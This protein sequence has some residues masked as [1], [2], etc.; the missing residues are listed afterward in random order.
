MWCI[1]GGE[2]WLYTTAKI[3]AILDDATLKK[4]PNHA[5]SK[6]R[7][8]VGAKIKVNFGKVE[9]QALWFTG[10]VTSYTAGLTSISQTQITLY[11]AFTRRV[12]CFKPLLI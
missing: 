8:P 4:Y 12:L 3:Q 10:T 9:G 7:P 2:R 6:A 11:A 1:I 5:Y